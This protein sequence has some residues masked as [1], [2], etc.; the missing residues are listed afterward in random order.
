MS[1]SEGEGE[2][3]SGNDVD[4]DAVEDTVVKESVGVLNEL[5]RSNNVNEVA[6]GDCEGHELSPTSP[7]LSKCN[8]SIGCGSGG[9]LNTQVAAVLSPSVGGCTGEKGNN[10]VNGIKRG[11]FGGI[12]EKG[13]TSKRGVQKEG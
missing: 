6:L 5:R 1:E 3:F 9:P 7:N 12:L 13:E 8:V 11:F 4:D 2:E 10:C